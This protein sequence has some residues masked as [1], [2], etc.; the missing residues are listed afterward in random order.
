M[1]YTPMVRD[2][3]IAD[4][5][6]VGQ[7][8]RPLEASIGR[9]NFGGCWAHRPRRARQQL[10]AV[11]HGS[12]KGLALVTLPPKF[13]RAGDGDRTRMA[14][15]EGW[16]V[17]QHRQGNNADQALF[18]LEDLVRSSHLGTP[19]ALR[20]GRRFELRRQVRRCGREEFKRAR[21]LPSYSKQ[22][23][24]SIDSV[25]FIDAATELL[26]LIQPPSSRSSIQRF[27]SVLQSKNSVTIVAEGPS[28]TSW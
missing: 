27:F 23:R 19:W 12:Q 14:S 20:Q 17:L 15:L 1:Q 22:A 2:D 28:G 26:P 9:V 25:L 10:L 13:A 4:T 11:V 16:R 6:E 3:V 21:G 18:L 24:S 8:A 7:A 5:L